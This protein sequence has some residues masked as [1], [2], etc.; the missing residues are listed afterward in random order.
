MFHHQREEVVVPSPSSDVRQFPEIVEVT[1]LMSTQRRRVISCCPV[2]RTPLLTDHSLVHFL[3]LCLRREE[4]VTDNGE[5][6]RQMCTDAVDRGMKMIDLLLMRRLLSN[7]LLHWSHMHLKRRTLCCQ[8]LEMI[9]M[10]QR[11]PIQ[12]LIASVGDHLN[13]AKFNWK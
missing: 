11:L 1:M 2:R 4:F 10:E 12:L 13:Q 8:L 3:L 5:K 6:R 9:E 7:H